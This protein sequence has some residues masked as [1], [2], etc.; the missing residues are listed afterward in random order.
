MHI[1]QQNDLELEEFKAWKR[2]KDKSEL[3]ETF[4]EMTEEN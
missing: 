4:F 1:E 3:E 2:A